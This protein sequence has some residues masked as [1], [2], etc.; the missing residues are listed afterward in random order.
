MSEHTHQE[1]NKQVNTIRFNRNLYKPKISIIIPVYDVEKYINKCLDSLVN[2]TLKEL[3]FICINDGSVDNSLNILNSYADNDNRFII[4]NQNNQGQG[5]A[6]NNGIKIAKGEYIAFVDPDDWL[7]ETALET[8][9]NFAV[10]NNANVVQF[11]YSKYYD[12]SNTFKQI[13]FSQKIKKQHKLDILK[14]NSYNKDDIKEGLFYNLDL[15]IFNRI[16]KRDFIIS[17][18]IKFAHTKNGEDHLFANGVLLF[19]DKIYFLNE[20]LY[21]YRTREDSAVNTKTLMNGVYAFEDIKCFKE[22][23]ENKNLFHKY[24]KDFYEYS[25]VILFW[26]YYQLPADYIS[27]YE[28]QC[29]KFLS[30]KYYKKF[31]KLFNKNNKFIHKIFSLKNIEENGKKIK[32]LTILGLKFKFKKWR[33]M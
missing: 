12:S 2:Q 9:Y 3:E 11:N 30:K 21:F 32:I 28:K 1:C 5:I 22:F 16:Y 14:S 10:K 33:K 19:A 17:N 26:H 13:D 29:E 23:L 24:E 18:Q 27:E 8:V 20:Y 6:R 7:K 15:H 4:I 31:K 25:I